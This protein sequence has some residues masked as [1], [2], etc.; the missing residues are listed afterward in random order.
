MCRVSGY[1][2]LAPNDSHKALTRSLP[3]FNPHPPPTSEYTH[4]MIDQDLNERE[5][6]LS[7]VS[8]GVREMI[9]TRSIDYCTWKHPVMTTVTEG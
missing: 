6:G 1:G 8:E 2:T 7:C 5:D 4:I 3:K 9:L